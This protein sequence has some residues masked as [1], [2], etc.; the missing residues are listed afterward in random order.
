MPCTVACGEGGER[1]ER[2]REKQDGGER[3][4][5][6][7]IAEGSWPRALAVFARLSMHAG[8]A[9]R[10]THARFRTR[11]S[12]RAAPPADTSGCRGTA[13]MTL[14]RTEEGAVAGALSASGHECCCHVCASDAL[15][16]ARA[17]MYALPCCRPEMLQIPE[18][19]L[20]Y[21]DLLRRVCA[22]HCDLLY[23]NAALLHHLLQTLDSGIQVRKL[24]PACTLGGSI[25]ALLVRA[26]HDVGIGV[27]TLLLGPMLPD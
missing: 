2:A 22:E 20:E 16:R 12:P 17:Y 8:S 7:A 11:P 14:S 23:T 4:N 5:L 10:S 21:F 15:V 3:G 18:I 25:G 26:C 24:Q 1:G 19:C 13:S 9:D 6:L 27:S